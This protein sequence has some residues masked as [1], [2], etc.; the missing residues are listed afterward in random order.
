MGANFFHS[1]L[2][3]RYLSSSMSVSTAVII[4]SVTRE[5]SRVAWIR[6]TNVRICKNA[7]VSILH[8]ILK[9]SACSGKPI[10]IFAVFMS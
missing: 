7:S 9:I 3:S 4:A 5:M 2:W 6:K 10:T 8:V 1:Q